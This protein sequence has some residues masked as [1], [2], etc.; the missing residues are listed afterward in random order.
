MAVLLHSLNKIMEVFMK[1]RK[2]ALFAALAVIA[3]I[4][5][6]AVIALGLA[7]RGG[8]EALEDPDHNYRITGQFA[9]WGSN[10]ADD[11]MMTC[12]SKSD[13]RIK[14]VRKALK[15]AQYV[16][17]YEHTPDMSNAAGWKITYPGANISVD[18]IFAVKIIRLN[19]DSRE[20]SGWKFG[21]RI[22]SEEAGGLRNLSPDTMFL[23]KDRSNEERDA[24]GDGLGGYNDY[25]ALLKGAVP[26][27][28]VFAVFKDKSRGM[29]AV[30]KG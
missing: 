7:E 11:Y 26:Y 19:H 14:A 12:V 6:V 25:P 16:Y 17:L 30:L 22:P 24:A 2:I 13:E 28:I 15:D 3:V 23:P 4:A 5:A 29:G 20:S 8:G 21:L 1:T 27:Y 18:G 10:Y 9:K